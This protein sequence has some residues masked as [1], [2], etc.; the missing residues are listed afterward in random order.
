MT[1][2][3]CIRDFECFTV[4]ELAYLEKRC[5]EIRQEKERERRSRIANQFSEA[6]TDVQM[7]NIEIKLTVDGQVI[8]LTDYGV[9]DFEFCYYE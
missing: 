9:A 3:D 7:A 1:V 2:Q 8:N 5:A 4:D 6:F